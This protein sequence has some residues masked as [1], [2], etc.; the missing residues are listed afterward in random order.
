MARLGPVCQLSGRCCRFKE[1]GHTLFVSTPE[2][3]LLMDNGAAA[4][5]ASGRGRNMPVARSIA[6]TAPHEIAGHWV[7]AF[8]TAIQHTN[9]LH[10]ACPS[11]I[12]A[13]LKALTDKHGLAV[14]LRPSPSPPAKMKCDS[15]LTLL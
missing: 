1:Y 2:V 5:A 10:T 6:D 13:R 8:I 14:E 11:A 15:F 4:A 7:A 12:I 9:R 3:Q